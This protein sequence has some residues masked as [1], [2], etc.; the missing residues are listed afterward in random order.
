MEKKITMIDPP[1][2][3]R[4]GFPKPIPE[5]RK[6]DTIPWLIEQGYPKKLIDEYGEYFACRYWEESENQESNENK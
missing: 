2:G 6:K 4:Y 3:W 1:G 5:D